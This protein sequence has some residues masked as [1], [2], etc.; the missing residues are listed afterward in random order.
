MDSTPGSAVVSSK[1]MEWLSLRRPSPD[2]PVVTIKTRHMLNPATLQT[3]ILPTEMG[4]LEHNCTE[5]HTHHSIP[6]PQPRK[7]SSPKCRRGLVHRWS[8]FM[9]EVKRLAGYALAS[10]TQVIEA[11]SPGTSAQKANLISLTQT[12]E[13]RSGE[14][15]NIYIDSQHVYAILH[16]PGIFGKKEVCSLWR[17]KRQNKA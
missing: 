13:L 4:L 15:L 7:W 12:L 6:V 14:T 8:S 2:N 17:I 16:T 10:L 9:R 5:T 3:A 1:G 11:L